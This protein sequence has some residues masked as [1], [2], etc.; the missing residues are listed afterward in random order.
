MEVT[1]SRPNAS[2]AGKE[3]QNKGEARVND[4]ASLKG[5]RQGTKK[6]ENGDQNTINTKL[7]RSQQKH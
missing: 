5:N 4:G 2:G 6:K 3:K 7:K 1:A